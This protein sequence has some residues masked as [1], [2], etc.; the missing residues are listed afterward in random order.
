MPDYGTA[1]WI[2]IPSIGLDNR[3]VEVGI[4][5]GVYEASW[6]DIG[7]QSD[8]PDPGGPGNSIFNGHVSTL[9]AG[10]VFHNLKDVVPGDAI[11]VYSDAFRTD[12]SVR[13]VYSVPRTATSFMDQTPDPQITLYTCDGRWNPLEGEFY[14][15]LVVVARLAYVETR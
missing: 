8:S 4:T 2:T 11:F 9:N 15:R 12:W 10:H 7:H 13:E 14:D 5:D 6:W 3:V 1:T